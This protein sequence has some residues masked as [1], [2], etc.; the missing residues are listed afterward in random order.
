M[1]S[2]AWTRYS[3]AT[4]AT[5]EPVTLDDLRAQIRSV[6]IEEDTLL[7][8][9]LSAARAAVENELGR[10]LITQVFDVYF[11]RFADILL[12]PF[13]PLASAGVT[14]VKYQDSNNVQQTASSALYETGEWCRRPLVRLKYNQ[15][16]PSTIGHADDVVI[17]ATFGY[18]ATALAVP[19]PIRQAIALWAAHM[20]EH[21]EPINIGNIA[22]AL[23]Y[24]IA[25]LIADY[26]LQMP[27]ED[28]EE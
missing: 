11:D 6:T 3:L 17:R 20:N 15:V 19:S 9:Y 8:A 2:R 18:G 5:C 26:R 4:D 21:R 24:G 14:S 28:G 16:W 13:G 12:L 27:N 10:K 22:T 23:P 25:D 7:S 1:S